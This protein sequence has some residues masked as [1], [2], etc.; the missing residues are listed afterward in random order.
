[1]LRLLRLL[2]LLALTI[3]LHAD[4]DGVPRHTSQSGAMS[5]LKSVLQLM[6]VVAGRCDEE[7]QINAHV[8]TR[9]GQKIFLS[10]VAI[11]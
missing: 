4:F 10:L 6:T 3:S 5:T 2:R 11:T 7:D 1:M 8:A 9:D